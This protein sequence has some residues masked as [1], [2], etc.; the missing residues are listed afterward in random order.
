MPSR[1]RPKARLDGRYA[2]LIG[3][4][5]EGAQLVHFGPVALAGVKPSVPPFAA[6]EH[7]QGSRFGCKCLGE[8]DVVM[9]R[10]L[11]RRG[12]GCTR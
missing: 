2:G 7:V 3:V 9:Q 1:P 10:R 4:V 12:G 5:R 8:R 6:Q 11:G